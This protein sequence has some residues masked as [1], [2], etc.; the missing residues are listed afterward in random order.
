MDGSGQQVLISILPI[1]KVS[2]YLWLSDS[3]KGMSTFIQRKPFLEAGCLNRKK[4]KETRKL[5]A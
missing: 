3:F 5:V 4:K 1:N 2:F